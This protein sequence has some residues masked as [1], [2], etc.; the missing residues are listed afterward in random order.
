MKRFFYIMTILIIAT[1][2][3]YSKHRVAFNAMTGEFISSKSF[4]LNSPNSSIKP[5][6]MM[7]DD[8]SFDYIAPSVKNNNDEIL[9]YTPSQ[10]TTMFD[11]SDS[12]FSISDPID[13]T[14]YF[15]T[16]FWHA[17]NSLDGSGPET[18]GTIVG[19]GQF[20]SGLPGTF[21]VDSV[22]LPF[23]V[24]P[25]WKQVRRDY[26]ML[27]IQITDM[28]LNDTNA[29]KNHKPQ[30]GYFIDFPQGNNWI[31]LNDN[32]TY[33][34]KDTINSRYDL[35]TNIT[36]WTKMKFDKPFTVKQNQNFGVVIQQDVETKDQDTVRF[37]GAREWGLNQ[38][39][40]HGCVLRRHASADT[41][42]P[43][44]IYHYSFTGANA[45]SFKSINNQN[46]KT[47]YNLI[48]FGDF[49]MSVEKL[50]D[51]ASSFVMEQNT[52]N[53][54]LNQTEVSFMIKQAG[55]VNLSVY[56]EMGQLVEEV[57]NKFMA[58]GTYKTN[59]ITSDYN[60]GNY[61]YNLKCNNQSTTKVMQVVR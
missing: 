9:E 3:I 57:I 4:Y 59:I 14:K 48:F 42:H 58:P 37:F 32:F 35:N 17:P 27:P 15:F 40:T 26:Q 16:G 46:L 7:S 5:Q 30:A 61:F 50:S 51:D 52:P 60:S 21:I 29:I 34:P 18:N 6:I 39:L 25:N 53:P 54:V 55:N 11:K 41:L 44:Y 56:N 8:K 2:S 43:S 33:I 12:A 19:F 20:V 23:F 22:Y 31:N 45:I 47:N 28:N 49:E 38:Y 36:A 1:L 24:H 10:V 13:S